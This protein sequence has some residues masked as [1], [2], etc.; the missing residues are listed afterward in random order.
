MS[1]YLRA[2]LVVFALV[3]GVLA[4]LHVVSPQWMS[5]VSHAIHGR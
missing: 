5:S 1:R 3:L 4:L 2:A